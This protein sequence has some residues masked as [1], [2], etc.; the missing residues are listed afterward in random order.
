MQWECN[1]SVYHT[2]ISTS[3]LGLGWLEHFDIAGRFD[4][5]LNSSWSDQGLH[6]GPEHLLLLTIPT[7]S[8]SSIIYS[9]LPTLVGRTFDY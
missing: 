8:S 9:Y 2:Y 3:W 4:E 7:T 1:G 6:F 5:R